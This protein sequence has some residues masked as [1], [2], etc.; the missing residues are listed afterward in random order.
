MHGLAAQQP[1]KRPA[2]KATGRVAQV[3]LRSKTH[4]DLIYLDRFI[5]TFK[6]GHSLK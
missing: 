3:G 6:R 2:S 4:H 5:H 1:K